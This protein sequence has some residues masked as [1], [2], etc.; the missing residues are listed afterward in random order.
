MPMARSFRL[1]SRMILRPEPPSSPCSG[2][3]RSGAAWKCCSKRF[4][5]TSIRL[6]SAILGRRIAGT[7][8]FS[9]ADWPGRDL[10]DGELLSFALT[11]E[12]KERYFWRGAHEACGGAD[13][14][15]G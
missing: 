14:M 1:A 13:I 8:S 9:I 2:W 5:R 3:I 11:N 6:T 10:I 12:A 4:L 7:N 15:Q